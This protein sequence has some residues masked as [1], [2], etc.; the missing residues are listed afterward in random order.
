MSQRL[1]QGVLAPSVNPLLAPL[2]LSLIETSEFNSTQATAHTSTPNTNA[3]ATAYSSNPQCVIDP[4]EVP[5]PTQYTFPPYNKADAAIYRYRQQQSVN[6]GGWFALESWMTPSIFGC[7]GG[8]RTSELDFAMGWET[9]ELA[10]MV[11]ERCAN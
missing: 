5:P 4:Y 3:T 7:A 9:P 1:V 11:I 10:R 8:N 2:G 6:L